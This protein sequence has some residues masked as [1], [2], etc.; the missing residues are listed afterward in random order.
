MKGQRID[1]VFPRF[2]L[3]SGAERAILG[4]A[5]ALGNEGHHARI[6]C[7]RFDPSCQS[8]LAAGVE[9]ECTGLRLD[10]TR[11]RYLNAVFDYAR[12]WQLERALDPRAD[13]QVF[14][15]PALPL[16]WWMK[17]MKRSQAAIL[18]YCWEPPRVLYQDR[19]LILQRLGR[20]RLALSP[21]LSAYR[22]LDRRMV[23]AVDAVATS[24]EF[25]ARRVKECYGRSAVVIT[26][27][28][29]RKRLDAARRAGPEGPPV[30]L[31][32]NYLHPRKRIAMT[33]EA[34]ALLCRQERQLG[35][36]LP[37]L[38]VV[39]GGP[40][41]SELEALAQ[42]LG[43]QRQVR[44]AGF[45][46]DEELPGYY[47]ES[48][49]YVHSAR[50]ESFGLSVIEAAYCA[51]PVVVVDEGGVQE[52]VQHGVTGYR[53]PATAD[54]LA[55]GIADLLAR[56]D[57]GAQLGEAGRRLVAKKYRWQRGAADLL[58]LVEDLHG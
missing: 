35:G 19:E 52:T 44:F 31:T 18:Y 36:E 24:S 30:L 21:G 29:D 37:R 6:V 17:K 25:A 10:W 22:G 5:E 40:E 20:L 53:V 26:L 3:L 8:R 27:G 55:G 57:R 54:G 14:F 45:I 13:L 49:C 4:L 56:P 43:V 34:L 23:A 42:R 1:L 47:W 51:R 50:E 15:G 11:N 9:L 2:K 41:K 16:A 38:L 33:L 12:T 7:H 32:V 28:V 58:A 39:G 46:A 48:T